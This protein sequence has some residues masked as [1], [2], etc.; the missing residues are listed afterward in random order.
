MVQDDE[1]LVQ[2]K[3]IMINNEMCQIHDLNILNFKISV[4]TIYRKYN[5]KISI[6]NGFSLNTVFNFHEVL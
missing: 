1:I 3:K 4:F 6:S 2:F 5:D